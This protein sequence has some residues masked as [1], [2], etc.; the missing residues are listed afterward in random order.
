MNGMKDDESAF[1]IIDFL[2][3]TSYKKLRTDIQEKIREYAKGISHKDQYGKFC[4]RDELAMI[5]MP[6]ILQRSA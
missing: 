1:H 4:F 5:V 2:L 6:A 3:N